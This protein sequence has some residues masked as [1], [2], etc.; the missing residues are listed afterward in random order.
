MTLPPYIPFGGDPELTGPVSSKNAAF[1]CFLLKGHLDKFQ[2]SLDRY[3][4]TPAGGKVEYKAFSDRAILMFI[5]IQHALT[6]TKE[7]GWVGYTDVIL[8]IPALKFEGGLPVGLV[9]FSPYIFVDNILPLITGRDV[10]GFAKTLASVTLPADPQH[11]DLLTLDTM[12]IKTLGPESQNTTMRL[13]E[14]TRTG[15]GDSTTWENEHEAAR[16]LRSLIF[17]EGSILDHL[18]E[19]VVAILEVLFGKNALSSHFVNLKQI[20]DIEDQS[21]AAYQAVTE[22]QMALRVWHSG[23]LLGLSGAYTFTLNDVPS[24]P[25]EADL[26]IGSQS[27]E[28]AWWIEADVEIATG[29]TIWEA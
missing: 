19:A 26:G 24:T 9:V 10:Y 27:V 12:G 16:Y 11:V 8:A 21:R 6:N 13:F 23:G 14:V 5:P 25:I 7:R 4:N 2:A 17:P 3:L 28:V 29:T 1:Y 20:R 18:I 22:T 15:A